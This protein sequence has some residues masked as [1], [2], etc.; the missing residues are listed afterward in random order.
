MKYMQE[1]NVMAKI[2]CYLESSVLTL[3]LRKEYLNVVI[4]DRPYTSLT[5]DKTLNSLMY[6]MPFYV[7]IYGSYKL[8]KTV[9]CLAHPVCMIMLGLGLG[10]VKHP[11]RFRSSFL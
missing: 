1:M 9:R 6:R 8:P 10:L 5:P 2:S 7:N 3:K 4:Y 11:L